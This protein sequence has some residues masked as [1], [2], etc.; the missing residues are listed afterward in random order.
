LQ[1]ANLR[2]AVCDRPVESAAEGRRSC[3]TAVDQCESR[4]A[5]AVVQLDVM[6]RDLRDSSEQRLF[7]SLDYLISARQQRLGD[8]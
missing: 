3:A 2:A 1:L 5:K 4:F 7:R 8:L 6:S